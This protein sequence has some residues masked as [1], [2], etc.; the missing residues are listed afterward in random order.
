MVIFAQ[1]GWKD[2]WMT[3]NFTSSSTVF[4]SYQGEGQMIMEGCVHGTPFMVEKISP[5]A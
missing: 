5:R 1:K 4:Q 3:C 2:A